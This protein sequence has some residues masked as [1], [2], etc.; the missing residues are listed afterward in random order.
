MK[1]IKNYLAIVLAAVLVI[2]A[3]GCA[4]T[5]NSPNTGA[6]S[7]TGTGTGSSAGSV[8]LM[9][10]MQPGVVEGSPADDTF[11]SGIAGF[12]IELFKKS[13]KDKENSLI[14]PLSVILALAMTANGA[15]GDTLAQMEG[16]LGSG[17]PLD[18]LNEYLYSYVKSLPN[19]ENSKMN[20]ANSIWFRGDGDAL[21]VNPDFLQRNADY[22][23]AAAFKAAFDAGT[24][25]DINS[26]VDENTD[27][28]INKI[29]DDIDES[30]M[31][32]LINAIMFD[33]K[34][35]EVYTKENLQEG[36]FT[37]I[38]GE[39]QKVEFMYSSE[40]RYLDDGMATGFIKPYEG[41]GYCFAALLPNEGISLETYIDSLTG[42]GF[43]DT[44]QNEV[45]VEVNA[46]MPKFEYDYEILMNEA[47]AGLGMPDAFDANNADFS[48]MATSP[49]ANLFISKVLHKTFISVD[50]LGTKA[51]AVTSVG[52]AATGMPV[53]I[54][55][56][57]LDRPFVYAIIDSA[58]DLPVFIGVV[59]TV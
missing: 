27:G 59:M 45:S 3:A 22:Y 4:S 37:N 34:W 51:G 13:I 57:R 10:D 29:L 44:L 52:I 12:S 58:T 23:G 14:S 5:G 32:F 55:E 48:R 17:I 38:N 39:V 15:D 25:K 1:N 6:S 36:D 16:L 33:A 49:G 8:N 24:V 20:I 40:F 56:V 41:G 54:K 11:T 47:L 26:W 28:L 7:S 35:Q 43:M 21:Q 2:S 19:E 30:D 18:S 42:A 53:E 50:E 46:A 31:L 9:K